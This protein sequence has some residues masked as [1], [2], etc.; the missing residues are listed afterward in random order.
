MMIETP[1]KAVPPGKTLRAL[2]QEVDPQAEG[3]EAYA[4]IE[5][6]YPICRS[7]TGNGTRKSLRLLQGIVPLELREVPSGTQVFDWIVPKE[8]NIRDAYI[9]NDAG[10]RVGTSND[11][12]SMS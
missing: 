11:P 9:K 5:A 12:I 3:R 4:I 2:L 10:E 1:R 8:W 7:I 6:L